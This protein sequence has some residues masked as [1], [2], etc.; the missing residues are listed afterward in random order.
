MKPFFIVLFLLSAS[1]AFADSFKIIR[2]GQE[3]ICKSTEVSDPGRVVDCATK[4]YNG[5]FSRDESMQLCSGAKD[6]GPAECGIKAYNGPFSRAEALELC[7]RSGTLANAECAIK[8]YNGPYSKAEAVRLCKSEPHLMMR[9][10][11]LMQQS[12]QIQEK[13]FQLK[14][15]T[16]ALR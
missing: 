16:P 8:A 2:E 13:V 10:L 1:S 9:S 6:I 15:A 11:D 14:M 5:P 12:P 3:Y 7:Q 4:A